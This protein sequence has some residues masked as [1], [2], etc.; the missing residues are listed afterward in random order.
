MNRAASDRTKQRFSSSSSFDWRLSLSGISKPLIHRLRGLIRVWWVV[1]ATLVF[2]A[3][4]R[5]GDISVDH[6]SLNLR[7]T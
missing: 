6:G 3:C 4:E 7:I 5:Y 1:H 2:A